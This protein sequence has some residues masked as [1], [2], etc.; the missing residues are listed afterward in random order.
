[1]DYAAQVVVC[2]VYHPFTEGCLTKFEAG[3]DGQ[4]ASELYPEVACTRIDSYLKR[5]V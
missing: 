1:M 3:K 2:H 5:Y 4:E